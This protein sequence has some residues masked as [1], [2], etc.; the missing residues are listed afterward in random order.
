MIV[1]AV[2]MTTAPAIAVIFNL[3]DAII[4]K[5]SSIRSKVEAGTCDAAF[6]N[7]KDSFHC[8]PPRVAAGR[9]FLSGVALTSSSN[10]RSKQQKFQKNQTPFSRCLLPGQRRLNW[11]KHSFALS[12][13]HQR[14][15]AAAWP[16]KSGNAENTCFSLSSLAL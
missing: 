15:R 9:W 5:V 10:T 12:F 16:P 2:K 7:V 13:K 4:F 1:P 6:V 11:R 3:C 8:I 14:E